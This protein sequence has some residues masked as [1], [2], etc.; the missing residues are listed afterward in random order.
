MIFHNDIHKIE[1]LGKIKSGEIRYAGNQKLKIYGL[2]K[3]SSG[4]RMR[5]ANRVFFS[6]EREALQ[7]GYR[8]CGHCLRD[9]YKEWKT[10]M[11]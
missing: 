5:R 6:N 2:L 10:N 9:K 1:M 8:P 7:N 11:I 4:K 3:C